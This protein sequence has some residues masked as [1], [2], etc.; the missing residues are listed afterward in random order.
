RHAEDYWSFQIRNVVGWVDLD[1]VRFRG[2]A[3]GT[4]CSGDGLGPVAGSAAAVLHGEGAG[5]GDGAVLV[6]E[7]HDALGAHGDG[8]RLLAVLGRDPDRPAQ[9][10]GE[11]H[12][13]GDHADAQLL[14]GGGLAGVLGAVDGQAAGGVG[15]DGGG[16]LRPV[17]HRLGQGL[18]GHRPRATAAP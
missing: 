8:P 1:P 11:G 18:G 14:D 7:L 10:G 5:V 15:A 4:L 2:G 3:L 13:T 9:P 16:D 17:R 6:D 12:A